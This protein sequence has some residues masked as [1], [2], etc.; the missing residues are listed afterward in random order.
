VKMAGQQKQRLRPV[1]S[2]LDENQGPH[3]MKISPQIDA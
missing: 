1:L 2:P 3:E